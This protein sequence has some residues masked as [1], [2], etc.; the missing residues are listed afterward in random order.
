MAVIIEE[1]FAK[2]HAVLPG[3]DNGA[4]LL[5]GGIENGFDRGRHDGRAEFDPQAIFEVLHTQLQEALDAEA[6]HRQRS[7]Q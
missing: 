5:L 2:K 7:A 6:Y 3:R 1:G 4:G